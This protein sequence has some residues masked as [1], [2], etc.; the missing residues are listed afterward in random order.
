MQV[1]GPWHQIQEFLVSRRT[2]G[3][4]GLVSK[5]RKEDVAEVF[6]RPELPLRWDDFVAWKPTG[7][8]NPKICALLL[9]N[10]TSGLDSFI[11]LDDNPMECNEVAAHCPEVTVVRLPETHSAVAFLQHVW[12]FDR[13]ATTSADRVRTEQ[14]QRQAHRKRLFRRANSFA[15]FFERLDLQ[16]HLALRLWI[17]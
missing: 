17:R 12:A 4:C 14:Y 10:L 11:F 13:G 1:T 3:C 15:E 16:V 6:S 5:N 9:Q 7:K 8:R 2:K